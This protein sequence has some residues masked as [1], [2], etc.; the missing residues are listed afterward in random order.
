MKEFRRLL[1]GTVEIFLNFFM[2]CT[3]P[4]TEILRVAVNGFRKGLVAFVVLFYPIGFELEN[5]S[6]FRTSQAISE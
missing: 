4:Q 2:Y 5:K 6:L 1:V 3:Q